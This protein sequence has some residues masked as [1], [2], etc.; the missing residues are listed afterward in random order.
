MF[1]NRASGWIKSKEDDKEIK[2]KAE[3]E[4]IVTK[5]SLEK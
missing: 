1:E 4:D 3:I 2:K 5:Q